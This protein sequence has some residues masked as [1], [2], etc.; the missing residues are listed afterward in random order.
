MRERE[1]CPTT[2]L[3]NQE[4]WVGELVTFTITW[5]IN[6]YGYH[7]RPGIGIG[8]HKTTLLTRYA[9]FLTSVFPNYMPQTTWMNEALSQEGST[10]MNLLQAGIRTD[11][12][13]LHPTYLTYARNFA[14][15]LRGGMHL[16]I[17]LLPTLLLLKCYHTIY[18]PINLYALY[19]L[20]HL[21]SRYC[22]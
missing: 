10:V 20:M 19:H 9:P 5:L 11:G 18:P 3:L 1:S 22:Y 7:Y 21:V 2:K 12:F 15:Q 13:R 6:Y 16:V 17:T 14:S 4:S 8:W